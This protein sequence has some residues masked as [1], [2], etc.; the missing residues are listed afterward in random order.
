V[1]LEILSSKIRTQSTSS[2]ASRCSWVSCGMED[3][4]AYPTVLEPR[5]VE[6]LDLAMNDSVAQRVSEHPEE[7]AGYETSCGHATSVLRVVALGISESF[8]CG[9]G[10]V[11]LT[12]RPDRST[13]LARDSRACHAPQTGVTLKPD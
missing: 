10:V 8:V 5:D 4:R 2:S 9:T 6:A 13:R 12:G 3:T 11:F 1:R 7:P